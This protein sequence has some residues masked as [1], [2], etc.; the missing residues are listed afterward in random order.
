MATKCASSA[1]AK[2]RIAEHHERTYSIELC[3]GTHV[4]RT[5]DIGLITI[6]GESAV[7]AG[8][9]RIEAK[10]RDEARKRLEADLRAYADLAGLLRAP[11]GEATERLE[12]LIEDQRKL[13]RELADAKR[14]LAMGGGESVR[15]ATGMA[16]GA[17]Q[18][19][20]AG[21]AKVGDIPVFFRMVQGLDPKDL[22]PLADEAKLKLGSGVVAVANSSPDGKGSLVVAVT[23]DY[24]ARISAI[25]LV[26]AGAPALGGKG[27]GGRPDM[28][29]AGG[30]DGSKLEESISAVSAKLDELAR[31]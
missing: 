24:A 25:D 27:G 22:K 13:E 11:A 16:E 31:R 8:V 17:A 23:P 28:A 9:R 14:K 7:A 2:S 15:Q 20:G 21:A 18:V 6:V 29:Q 12:A 19:S 30:P 26:R 5:G 1:W 4:H 10:T 3:G